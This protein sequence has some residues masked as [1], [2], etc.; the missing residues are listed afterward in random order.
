VNYRLPPWLV[1]VC[2]VAICGGVITGIALYQ[3]KRTSNAALFSRLPAAD[4]VVVYVDFRALRN[5]GVLGVLG[6]SRVM[7]EPE[8]RTFV[9]Q[10]R[11]DYLNDLD[12][13]F[14]SFHPRGT[15]FLL[16]GRFDWKNLK[17]YTVGQGGSCHNTL[18]RVAGSAPDRKISYFPL[19]PNVMALAVS[20]DDS[21]ATELQASR[22]EPKIT[23]PEDP[24]WS[25]IPIHAIKNGA[26]VPA[27]TR[28][29]AR[30]LEGADAV[31]L[32]A[33]PEG[34]RIGL[35]MDAACRSAAD[36]R[37]LVAGLRDTTARLR[38][39][40]ARENQTPNANDLSGVLAAG[41]FE[42]KDAHVLG[43]WPIER[44]FLESLAGGA[45]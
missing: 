22:S 25:L 43:R 17:E 7:Q 41:A 42:L 10:T 3:I 32:S 2:L 8:Y 19:Q 40:I 45:L 34:G 39:L 24:V 14:V 37:A 27:G 5:A 31:V 44:S 1:L 12:A 16:R 20:R 9:D 38:D 15:Y 6:S 28:A 29:F 13:A 4:A 26:H 36:A 35:K 18:C 11:F 21:A 23:M 30:A 33:A